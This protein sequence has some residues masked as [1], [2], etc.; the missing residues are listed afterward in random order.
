MKMKWNQ[1]TGP[2]HDSLGGLVSLE[3]MQL[4]KNQLSGPIPD[5]F[6]DLVEL[7][8]LD[9]SQNK[10][11]G[12]IPITLGNL[13]ELR[14]LDLSNNKLHGAIPDT[15]GN[16]VALRGLN[17]S[18]NKLHGK[19]PSLVNLI[20]LKQMFLQSNHFSSTL[21]QVLDSI[22]GLQLQNLNVADNDLEDT[23]MPV[24]Y[25]L[26]ISEDF[27]DGL[28]SIKVKT[29]AIDI[30]A[31]GEPLEAVAETQAAVE[32]LILASNFDVENAA[33]SSHKQAYKLPRRK[34]SLWS[35]RDDIKM[36]NS[37]EIDSS[38]KNA[39]RQLEDQ[40]LVSGL[41][42]DI[43]GN[44][45]IANFS[46]ISFYTPEL[47][48]PQCHI[49]TVSAEAYIQL[50][51][52][53]DILLPPQSTSFT[54]L[55]QQH[56]DFT[57]QFPPQRYESIGLPIAGGVELMRDLFVDS[58]EPMSNFKCPLPISRAA[59]VSQLNPHQ[60][61]TDH[62]VAISPPQM[63][64]TSHVTVPQS[65]P[66]HQQVF[67]G[68][69]IHFSPTH[70]S[71]HNSPIA[72]SLFQPLPFIPTSPDLLMLAIPPTSIRYNSLMPTAEK[73][74]EP[75]L[76]EWPSTESAAAAASSLNSIP[77]TNPRRIERTAKQKAYALLRQS[78]RL[79][80]DSATSSNV[81]STEFLADNRDST[82]SRNPSITP[83]P[84][85]SPSSSSS[86]DKTATGGDKYG[87]PEDT[88]TLVASEYS[89]LEL[90]EVAHG[91]DP[92]KSTREL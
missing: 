70:T 49:P 5:T 9:L 21:S 74:A 88:W 32:P 62:L 8:E 85:A 61:V 10:L 66:F 76:P 47:S 27:Y 81:D 42:L 77:T 40:L 71:S 57:P 35:K 28:D 54:T 33:I 4:M 12:E 53:L 18:R 34:R 23:T 30:S 39:Q 46:P 59:S 1:L 78:L 19:I 14:K 25:F 72:Q 64:S 84:Q 17:L 65:H 31:V 50:G 73:L 41:Q 24:S 79:I 45:N 38:M 89:G 63:A 16:L 58:F 26:Q 56:L 90:G 87:I 20:Q 2:I 52:A 13:V 83:S 69:S 22:K 3:V 44:L 29:P 51:S 67:G 82:K 75:Q 37:P 15:L 43:Q 7:M 36:P 11:Q 48:L 60:L 86:S 68:S 91:N 92:R 6:G 55:P 80:I